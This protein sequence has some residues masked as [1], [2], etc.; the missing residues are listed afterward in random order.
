MNIKEDIILSNTKNYKDKYD[1]SNCLMYHQRYMEIINVYL[2]YA[3]ENINIQ[4]SIYFTFII[5]R[6]LTSLFHIFHIIF[7]YTKN[8]DLTLIHCK[9]ALYY[10]IEFIGQ[11][12]DESHSYLQLNSKDAML[13]I[14]KKTIFEINSEHRTHFELDENEKQFMERF[15]KVNTIANELLIYHFGGKGSVGY[16]K[17]GDGYKLYN[18]AN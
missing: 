11:I 10:Y 5:H 4:N 15:T 9:K 16:N 18:S 14:Y 2:E 12:G 17:E 3:S 6:G 1:I 13:F 8:I 7:L